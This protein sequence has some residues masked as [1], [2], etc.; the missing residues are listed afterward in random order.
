MDSGQPT[1]KNIL[2]VNGGGL[3]AGYT[4]NSSW[5]NIR[6]GVDNEVN[7][8]PLL[9]M[10]TDSILIADQPNSAHWDVMLGYRLANPVTWSRNTF[11]WADGSRAPG[12]GGNNQADATGALVTIHSGDTNDVTLDATNKYFNGRAAAGLPPVGT[13]PKGWRDYLPLMPAACTDPIGLVK[14]P[15]N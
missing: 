13:Y 7:L 14:I 3:S 10:L 4:S 5:D 1:F 11:V 2:S 8:S 9:L 12:P 6:Y 15:A